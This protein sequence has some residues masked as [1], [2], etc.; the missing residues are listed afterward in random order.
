MP[1]ARPVIGLHVPQQAK[2]VSRCMQSAGAVAQGLRAVAATQPKSK[3]VLG[4]KQK[5][6]GCGW[7]RILLRHKP[8]F[9]RRQPDDDVTATAAAAP[10]A[11]KK[12]GHRPAAPPCASPGPLPPHQAHAQPPLPAPHPALCP[13][14]RQPPSYVPAPQSRPLSNRTGRGMTRCAAEEVQ[15]VAA[16]GRRGRGA[17]GAVRWWLCALAAADGSSTDSRL[18]SRP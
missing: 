10:A 18:R 17:G 11:P 16:G 12:W 4:G 1:S 6:R 5:Q 3:G 9:K 8:A 15:A 7:K 14:I 2:Q 13:Y